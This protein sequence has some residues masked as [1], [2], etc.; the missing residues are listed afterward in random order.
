MRRD[1]AEAR[2]LNQEEFRELLEGRVRESLNMS[3]SEFMAA[4]KD[5]RLDP[6]SPRVASLAILLGARAS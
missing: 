6:E 1:D 5:G 2:E 3:L 4:L